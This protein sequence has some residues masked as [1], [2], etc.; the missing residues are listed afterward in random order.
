MKHCADC[1]A[2][3]HDNYDDNVRLVIV[4][5]PD[6]GQMKRAYLCESHRVMYR[7]DGYAVT[8]D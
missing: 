3:E 1:R 8:G 5:D 4:R 6:N 2:G 7:D